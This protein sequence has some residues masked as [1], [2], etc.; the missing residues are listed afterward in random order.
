MGFEN[1]FSICEIGQV[2]SAISGWPSSRSGSIVAL[3]LS[4]V[5]WKRQLS[6]EQRRPY[7]LPRPHCPIWPLE[8]ILV[9]NREATKDR[10]RITAVAHAVSC[11]HHRRS[12]LDLNMSHPRSDIKLRMPTLQV[13]TCTYITDIEVFSGP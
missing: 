2:Y 13:H 6:Y 1:P 10:A 9:T 7:S 4:R 3:F 8:S 12:S 11:I 5:C